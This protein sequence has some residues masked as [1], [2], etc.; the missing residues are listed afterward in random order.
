MNSFYIIE[1]SKEPFL[2]PG[3]DSF[4]QFDVYFGVLTC[5]LV[6]LFSPNFD[7]IIYFQA[8]AGPLEALTLLFLGTIPR[9]GLDCTST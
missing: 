4:L 2:T 5:S 1:H 7:P 6:Y 8:H 9:Q 3:L